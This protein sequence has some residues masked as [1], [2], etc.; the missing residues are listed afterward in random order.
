MLEAPL[1]RQASPACAAL[2]VRL[3]SERLEGRRRQ[4][5]VLVV[6]EFDLLQAV[7]GYEVLASLRLLAA[8]ACAEISHT[9][10]PVAFNT[11]SRG[12]G[13]LRAHAHAHVPS[14]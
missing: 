12:K 6:V 3:Q 1:E 7:V 11:N 9:P 4:G 14:S 2:P 13:S 8:Q 10:R 5:L